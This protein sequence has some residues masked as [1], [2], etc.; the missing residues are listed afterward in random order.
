[1]QLQQTTTVIAIFADTDVAGSTII[2]NT[3]ADDLCLCDPTA[4]DTITWYG[5]ARALAPFRPIKDATGSVITQAITTGNQFAVP[6]AVKIFPYLKLK[7]ATTP[8]NVA[9]VLR[10]V[11]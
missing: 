9:V 7:A 4:D 6:A 10:D 8:L 1:M 11:H 2:S 3:Q 5:A